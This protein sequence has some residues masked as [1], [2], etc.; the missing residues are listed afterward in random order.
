MCKSLYQTPFKIKFTSFSSFLA[1][2]SPVSGSYPGYASGLYQNSNQHVPPPG[3]SHGYADPPDWQQPGLSIYNNNPTSENDLY[4]NGGQYDNSWQQSGPL[5]GYNYHQ[6]IENH[7]P[8]QQHYGYQHGFTRGPAQNYDPYYHG[9]YSHRP[10]YVPD[11]GYNHQLIDQ[12][13]N[14]LCQRNGGQECD[15]S[16]SNQCNGEF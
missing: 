8:A 10:P 2:N 4:G 14:N 3:F 16:V 5:H 7:S 9:W 6:Q 15:G 11:N 12:P 13:Y 1:Q